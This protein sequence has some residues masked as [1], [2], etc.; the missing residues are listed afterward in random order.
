MPGP[1]FRSDAAQ[2][3]GRSPD[4]KNVFWSW[5]EPRN[6][7]DWIGPF[8]FRKLLGEEPLFCAKSQHATTDCVF[9]CGSI[10]RHL[11][12]PDR[13][14]V[15]GSGIIS[16]TDTYA[17]P[18]EVLA[19]RGP[20]TRRSMLKLG[21][22]C[23][24]VF[25][26]PAVLL[27]LF[28]KRPPKVAGRIG[29]IPHFIEYADYKKRDWTDMAVID[30]CRPVELVATDIASCEM[31]Y[32]SSLH[33]VI[34]SH[35]FGV[36]SIWMESSVKLDGDD[37][38]FHDYFASCGTSAAKREPLIYQG[39]A[40]ADERLALMPSHEGLRRSLMQALPKDWHAIVRR[41]AAA[42]GGGG[43]RRNT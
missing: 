27:P 23:P 10:L 32:S 5:Y 12:Y 26:D 34:V 11:K 21:Y 37:V 2:S 3:K 16:R 42:Y 25:G 43:R 22:E 35:A 28:I 4:Y 8:L 15:W 6:F 29:I 18:K 41:R 9:T 17:R 30:V 39:T 20:E 14:T 36:P 33:G 40:A 13:V 24:E 38:K 19:V 7:G 31:T 1:E